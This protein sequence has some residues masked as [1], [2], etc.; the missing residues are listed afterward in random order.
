MKFALCIHHYFPTGGLQQDFLKLLNECLAHQIDVDIFTTSWQAPFIPKTRLVLIKTRAWCNHKNRL[1][2]SNQCLHYFKKNYYDL[3]IGFNKQAGLDVYFA[4]D[5]CYITILQQTHSRLYHFLSRARTYKKLEASI[6]T[7]EKPTHVLFIAP[8]QW[9]HYYQNYKTSKHRCTLLPPDCKMISS[10]NHFNEAQNLRAQYSANP[11]DFIVLFVA[12]SFKTKGL[13]RLLLALASLPPGLQHKTH[14]WIV[15]NDNQKPYHRLAKQLKL[16][17]PLSFMGLQTELAPYYTAAD[18]LVHPARHEAAGKVLLEAM[19]YS[20][21]V[22]TTGIC[23]YS[24]YVTQAQAGIVSTM[25]FNQTTFNQQLSF[26]LN[27]TRLAQWQQTATQYTQHQNFKCMHA[28]AMNTLLMLARQKHSKTH[29]SCQDLTH[30]TLTE[31]QLDK[32]CEQ[33][34]DLIQ[35]LQQKNSFNKAFKLSGEI[36]RDVPSRRTLRFELNNHAYFIKCHFGIG[37]REIFKNFLQVRRPIVSARNEWYATQ[38]LQLLNIPTTPPLCFAQS[39][40]NPATRRS[41]LITNEVSHIR[42]LDQVIASWQQ[43]SPSPRV[44]RSWIKR[45]A[46]IVRTLHEAG[47]NHCDCYLC[48]FAVPQDTNP[49]QY[50]LDDTPVYLL[51]LHRSQICSKLA[52]RWRIKDLAALY[53]STRDFPLSRSNKF[54][55]IQQYHQLSLRNSFQQHRMLWKLV[56]FKSE[57]I[58]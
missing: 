38:Y 53:Y 17:I 22:L 18:L 19:V 31:F 23:G 52:L 12:T 2:F 21:A 58:A 15:G 29:D 47:M 32:N 25:P 16:K 13:R 46:W 54:Y 10:P 35:W 41:F 6:F 39:G 56:K 9:A 7:G 20:N 34:P 30:S 49:Q 40:R 50:L 37:W 4:G 45:I 42:G 24:T 27:K 57:K 28:I 1:D 3:I 36:F 44:C 33:H 51:D 8:N 14:C 26:M 55:F 48:H 43:C 11:D 5:D